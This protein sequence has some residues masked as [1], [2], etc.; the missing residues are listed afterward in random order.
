MK[1][2]IFGLAMLFA[3]TVQAQHRHH[4]GHHHHGPGW[5]W[6]A[7]AIIGGAVVYGITRPRPPEPVYYVQ[8]PLTLPPAPIGYYYTQMLDG[9]CNCYRWVLMPN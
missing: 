5:G 3:V 4:H 8:Q 1:K 7:P 6:V 2:F 9:N